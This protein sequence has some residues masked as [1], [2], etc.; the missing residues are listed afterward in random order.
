MYLIVHWY[1]I[2]LPELI[3]LQV[4]AKHYQ[5]YVATWK[6]IVTMNVQV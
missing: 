2:K 5:S 1:V 4:C 6:N 3:P